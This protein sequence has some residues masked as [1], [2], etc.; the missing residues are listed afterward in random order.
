M[1]SSKTVSPMT[2]IED[3]IGLPAYRM[4]AINDD[5]LFYL[6]AMQEDVDI[7]RSLRAHEP[8]LPLKKRLDA[9]AAEFSRIAGSPQKWKY[10]MTLIALPNFTRAI[11]TGVHAETERQI[12]L[13]AVAL[14]RYELAYLH[15]PPDL[16]TLVPTFLKSMPVDSINGRALSYH[17][18][19][20]GTFMLY[21]VGDDGRDDGG[22]LSSTGTGK[23]DF[24]SGRDAVWPRPAA[25]GK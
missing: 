4:T 20:D 3:Y 16:A 25:N 14:R 8:W 1:G 24:W 23:L 21:S 5:Q 17:T 10:L 2:V 13:T 12:T 9:R 11:S 22:D 18:N 7:T 6:K 19:P 15:P